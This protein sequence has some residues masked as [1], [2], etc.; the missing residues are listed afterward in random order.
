MS[1]STF[2]LKRDYVFSA[3]VSVLVPG[4][5]ER[6]F[7]ARFRLLPKSELDQVVG[8]DRVFLRAAVV[9]LSGITA[10][11]TGAE[12][13]WS[14]ELLGQLLDLDFVV[15]GL[16]DAYFAGRTETLEKN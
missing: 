14:P 16:I 8:D 3:P 9:D 2:V 12:M 5:G 11:D 6:E 10:E 4:E 1:K 13:P 15:K 7:T